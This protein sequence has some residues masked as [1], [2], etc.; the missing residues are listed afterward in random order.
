MSSRLRARGFSLTFPK[1]L[2]ELTIARRVHGC[3]LNSI[4]IFALKDSHMA[5]LA[6]LVFSEFETSLLSSDLTRVSQGYNTC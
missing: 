3:R 1:P 4:G 6:L 2:L 5:Q